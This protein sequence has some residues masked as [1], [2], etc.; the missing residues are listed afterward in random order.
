[1]NILVPL[2]ITVYI[3]DLIRRLFTKSFIELKTIASLGLPVLIED[4]HQR[5]KFLTVEAL[6]DHDETII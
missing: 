1:M 2:L 4:L 5:F 6:L 3:S